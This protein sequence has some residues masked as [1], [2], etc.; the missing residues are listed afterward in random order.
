MLRLGLTRS[1]RATSTS[2]RNARF[3]LP[4]NIATRSPL[5][6]SS[7]RFNSSS[8]TTTGVT[9]IQD[10][11]TSFDDTTTSA[12]LENVTNLH[13]DQL[14][15]LQSIGLA[16]GWGPTSLIERLLEVTHVYTGLPWW[17]TIVVATIAVRLI[18]FPLYVRASSNAT[19]MSKI[20]PQI[21]ELL[22]QIKTG[23]TVEQM[24]AMEKRRLIMKEN[25]V[26]TL[27]TL[28]PAVQLPLAYGFFQALRKMANHNV[29]GFSDQGYAWFQ[30]L[31][32]VDPYLGLQVISAAAIIAVV[33]VG[34]ETGQHAMAAGMKKVMTVVPIASIF[35][36]KGFASAIILYF[37]VNSIFSLIQSSLFK[38]SWFRKIAGMPPKLS[39]AE[40]Q[41]NNPKANQSIKDM[42]S[43][44]VDDSKEKS[45]K[46]AR[47][48]NKKLE[49][50]QR[51]KNSVNQG[52]IKRH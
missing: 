42:V 2:L 6:Y 31:I 25:G 1:F 16:Q 24:R 32:E 26:S 41:A 11:L 37:A 10:K 5:L 4:S 48:T 12:V 50:T 45:I 21:D 28:F 30:N 46:Q 47:E 15:Y 13:S 27:A 9:E 29:E 49:A 18:L 40:M 35:I 51:R 7:I 3:P 8:T 33:R 19:K 36:T 34:G 20:K 22:Q 52:F 23:D 39:L 38:S 14:G 44:F 43:K 17:G